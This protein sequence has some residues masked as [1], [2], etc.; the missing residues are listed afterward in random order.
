MQATDLQKLASEVA[1]VTFK[2]L[3][4]CQEKEERLAKQFQISV[5]EFRALR[6]FRGDDHLQIKELVRRVGLSGSR[7][8]RII[9]GLESNGFLVRSIDL[10]DRRSIVVT[11]TDK[12]R[13]LTKDLEQRYVEIHEEILEE[14]PPEMHQTVLT[15]LSKML[16]S[17]EKWLRQS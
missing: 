7:L 5:P 1:E 14:I 15:S 2:L 16:S 3:A 13:R 11:L 6:L 17:L 8:T 10:D 4:N 12:G 9:D